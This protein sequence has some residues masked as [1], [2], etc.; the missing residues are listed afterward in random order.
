MS[1]PASSLSQ[2]WWYRPNIDNNQVT[3][4]R[5]SSSFQFNNTNDDDKCGG[6]ACCPNDDKSPACDAMT[7]TCNFMT[8]PQAGAPT[9]PVPTSSDLMSRL[10]AAATTQHN[11]PRADVEQRT[12]TTHAQNKQLPSEKGGRGGRA[13]EQLFTTRRAGIPTN[14]ARV[15]IM[16]NNLVVVRHALLRTRQQA[17]PHG[18]ATR[19]PQSI[20]RK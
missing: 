12:T 9:N 17:T 5:A 3:A 6:A 19:R 20:H 15:L 1:E 4:C 7:P 13:P 10:P 2:L 16:I 14:V 8:S 18:N 11:T